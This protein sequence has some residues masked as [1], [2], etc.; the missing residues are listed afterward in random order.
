VQI[1]A[2]RQQARDNARDVAIDDDV[3]LVVSDAKDGT[4][5]VVSDPWERASFRVCRGKPAVKFLNDSPCCEVQVS[6]TAVIAESG[7]QLQHPFEWRLGQSFDAGEHS[8]KPQEIRNNRIHL[9]LL[10]HDLRDPY[11]V[12][13]FVLSPR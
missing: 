9:R 8:K 7:P 11:G 12:R 13:V 3:R 6:G 1:T 5:G 2:Q 4:R 10:E